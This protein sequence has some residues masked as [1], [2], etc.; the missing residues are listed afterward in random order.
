[1]SRIFVFLLSYQ[2]K[3]KVCKKVLY[4][5]RLKVFFLYLFLSRL[6]HVAFYCTGLLMVEKS[7][8]VDGL[9]IF[10]F[11]TVFLRLWST[12]VSWVI[13]V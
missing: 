1:M 7:R 5:L 6:V 8:Y 10:L 9:G 12:F 3:V 11:F 4:L 2:F 13:I